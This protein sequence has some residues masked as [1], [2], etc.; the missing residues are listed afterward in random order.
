MQTA[1]RS[2]IESAHNLLAKARVALDDAYSNALTA[3]LRKKISTV[4]T[5]LYVVQANVIQ[6]HNEAGLPLPPP[7]PKKPKP[8]RRHRRTSRRRTSRATRSHGWW[9]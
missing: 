2:D 9:T 4:M 6:L 3:G 8:N 7:K 1:A 5:D